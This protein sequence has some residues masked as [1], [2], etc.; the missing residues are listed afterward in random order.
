[1]VQI[2]TSQLWW[3]CLLSDKPFQ[4]GNTVDLIKS[5]PSNPS[6]HAF[7]W[8]N[9][10]LTQK[11]NTLHHACIHHHIFS[12]TNSNSLETPPNPNTNHS[13]T[14]PFS[15]RPTLIKGTFLCPF[16]LGKEVSRPCIS[17]CMQPS[18]LSPSLSYLA[19]PTSW[20]GPW[21]LC[22]PALP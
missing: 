9:I 4:I 1:M 17:W 6:M 15:G 5:C 18:Y 7:D 12:P 14:P 21:P 13:S 16:V 2:F 8:C 3:S 19:P 22:M 20:A 11:C 10:G